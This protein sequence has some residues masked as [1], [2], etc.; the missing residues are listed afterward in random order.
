M[1]TAQWP[2]FSM[3]MRRAFCYCA[4]LS[5]HAE[6]MGTFWLQEGRFPTAWSRLPTSV[7]PSLS[8]FLVSPA[9]ARM[10]G[11]QQAWRV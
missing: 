10:K 6:R 11:R 5:V 4:L 9:V 1:P 2:P 8:A 3:C 7:L